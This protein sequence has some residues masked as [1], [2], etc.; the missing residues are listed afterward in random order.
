MYICGMV[1][2]R[3]GC[4][5]SDV[6]WPLLG[7]DLR[8][9][10][11]PNFAITEFSEVQPRCVGIG[12]ASAPCFL[13][14]TRSM[15]HPT[16]PRSSCAQAKLVSRALRDRTDSHSRRLADYL[17]HFIPLLERGIIFRSISP[18]VYRTGRGC[19]RL[20]FYN[21]AAAFSNPTTI[22]YVAVAANAP[23]GQPSASGAWVPTR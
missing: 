20:I 18:R 13:R 14:S 8:T 10:A 5:L 11:M 3:K 19:R 23:A 17:E 12:G 9:G 4:Y 15:S 7:Q 6:L 21:L 1:Y 16:S 2:I 22:R